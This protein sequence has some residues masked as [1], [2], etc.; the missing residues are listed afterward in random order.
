MFHQAQNFTISPSD[1]Y[2]VQ[3]NQTIINR[4]PKSRHGY[5]DEIDEDVQKKRHCE[6]SYLDDVHTQL[7]FGW[8]RTEKSHDQFKEV[9]R[10][11]MIVLQ[12]ISWQLDFL[13][14]LSA[15]Q[16]NRIASHQEHGATH[17]LVKIEVVKLASKKRE[18]N[19]MAITYEGDDAHERWKSDL[20][21]FAHV[22]EAN[23]WHLYAF[24]RSISPSLIFHQELIPFNLVWM[25]A[26]DAVRSYL[27][28]RF[29]ADADALMIAKERYCQSIYNSSLL[30]VEEIWI[31]PSNGTFCWGPLCYIYAGVPFSGIDMQYAN[32]GVTLQ[33]SIPPLIQFHS[34]QAIQQYFQHAI[35]ENVDNF[36][37]L[38]SGIAY[39][40]SADPFTA[41]HLGSMVD[42]NTGEVVGQ[43]PMS[44]EGDFISGSWFISDS[45]ENYYPQ[46]WKP[47]LSIHTWIRGE[48]NYS[49]MIQL[50]YILDQLKIAELEFPS[51][52]M[53]RD[54][55]HQVTIPPFPVNHLP[56]ILHHGTISQAF[57]FLPPVKK[58][59]SHGQLT[60]QLKPDCSPFWSFDPLG[61][62]KMKPATTNLL[63]IPSITRRSYVG[64]IQASPTLLNAI[65]YLHKSRGYDP[66]TN[67][68]VQSQGWPTFCFMPGYGS[69]MVVEQESAAWEDGSND[70]EE[71][72]YNLVD[73]FSDSSTT[74]N[75]SR[76]DV[77][78]SVRVTFRTF[79]K[80]SGLQSVQ[81]GCIPT[82]DI[83]RQ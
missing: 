42:S 24:T 34:S 45:P 33:H 81:I 83:V 71:E 48:V 6:R 25:K 14:R 77:D 7:S 28:W 21:S 46:I 18:K 56:Q 63:G 50:P 5:E 8:L 23:S 76:P 54:V 52:R 70:S 53:M 20:E 35:E 51:F 10:G 22:R 61:K 26:S 2:V 3:G 58:F 38:S 12:R 64:Y 68:Y 36:L 74:N 16:P 1:F 73:E 9:H 11:D 43:M 31:D 78:E 67:D 55:Q 79:G 65:Q 13:N 4:Y 19:F 17:S 75:D 40:I 41:C 66:K 39:F 30:L 49:W 57:L 82:W 59:W 15:S 62:V 47:N 27:E 69:E 72:V 80:R 32:P 29:D 44:S 60:G 37:N